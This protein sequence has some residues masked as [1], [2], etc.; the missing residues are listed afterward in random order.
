MSKIGIH[1]FVWSA[2]SSK[3]ELER[4]L[5]RSHELGFKLVE[6]SYLDPEQVDV[7][8]LASRIRELRPG[9]RD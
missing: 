2:G 6:F 8:W 4:T 5:A 1:S 3:D 9:C 7:K